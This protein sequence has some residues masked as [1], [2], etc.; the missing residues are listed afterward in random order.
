V[1]FGYIDTPRV[2]H[3]DDKKMSVDYACNVIFWILE[4]NHRVKEITIC[5]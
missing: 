1:R 2:E 4:Q 5:P 3:V